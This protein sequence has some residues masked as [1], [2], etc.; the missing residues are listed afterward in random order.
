MERIKVDMNIQSSDEIL[1]MMYQEYLNCPT[2]IK[3][4]KKLGLTDEQVRQNIAKIY[5]FVR[6]LNYCTKCPGID[7]CKKE[8]PLF[9]TRI[10]YEYGYVDANTNPCKKFLDR[11]A[12]QSKF[13]IRDFDD[14]YLDKTIKD[15][16]KN[17]NR[18][19]AIKVYSDAKNKQ[20]NDWIYLSGAH[21][22]GR[23]FLATIFAVDY[24]RSGN[25]QVIFA[26]AGKRLGELLDL[27]FNNKNEF[28]KQL[29]DYCSVPLLVLDDFG[30]EVKTDLFR[31]AILFPIITTRASKK[32]FTIITSD[33]S[34]D[35]VI[36]L[37]SYSKNAEIRAKQLSRILK[38]AV[39]K[40]INLGSLSI[41]K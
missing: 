16:D 35:E 34:I 24:A 29:E 4:L 8:N 11:L 21:S 40:E 37:Y 25:N 28:K 9:C 13:I 19:R 3:Y 26:N 32:L 27:Y 15:V 23:S 10:T 6:D 18:T 7:K 39:K 14:E 33:Y 41:Y 2:A 31:D 36:E 38:E 12:F 20:I 22:T 1:E 30:N 5:D 17:E